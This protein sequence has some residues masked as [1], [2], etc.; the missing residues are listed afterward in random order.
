MSLSHI[1]YAAFL[2][3]LLLDLGGLAHAVAQ[4]VQLGAAHT[5]LT[6]HL[7]GLHV[8]GVQGEHALH[9]YAVGNAAHGEGLADAAALAGDHG[10]FELL[11]T[12]PVAFTDVHVHADGV[13]DGEL[14]D[15]SLER[16]LR[17]QL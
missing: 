14:G 10:A 17:D 2:L 7:H 15:L 12:L 8:G 16:V 6:D 11:D 9:T 13:T 5:A 4:I 3:K 1:S